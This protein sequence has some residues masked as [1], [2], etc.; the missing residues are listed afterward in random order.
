VRHLTDRISAAKVQ[1]DAPL[2]LQMLVGRPVWH[3]LLAT[4]ACSRNG[5]L[6]DSGRLGRRDHTDARKGPSSL[7]PVHEPSVHG[8]EHTVT[9][10]ESDV[11]LRCSIIRMPGCET[12]WREQVED[13]AVG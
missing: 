5:A 11:T 3:D 9:T 10:N 13:D 2:Q 6:I 7:A 12:K 1:I 4:G 8:S